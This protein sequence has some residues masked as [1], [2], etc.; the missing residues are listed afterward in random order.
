M[1]KLT[2]LK[3][4]W[5]NE[6]QQ[7]FDTTVTGL[8]KH[9]IVDDL[10]FL[11][12]DDWNTL[13]K[14]TKIPLPLLV[15]LRQH[16]VSTYG[17]FDKQMETTGLQYIQTPFK[18]LNNC[19][20]GGL[21]FD[22]MVEVSSGNTHLLEKFFMKLMEGFLTRYPTGKVIHVDTTGRFQPRLINHPKMPLSQIECYKAFTISTIS[23]SLEEYGALKLASRR[24]H[25]QDQ[26][27]TLIVI[28]DIGYLLDMETVADQVKKFYQVILRLKSMSICVTV[29]HSKPLNTS[30]R[31]DIDWDNLL[32]MRLSLYSSGGEPMANIIKA[33]HVK[34]P[35]SCSLST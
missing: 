21:R 27:S 24:R 25:L 23:Q 9:G 34:T 32:D 17:L 2:F 20:S 3:Q 16:L 22:D 11:M 15:A 8:E 12:V 10:T 26:H 4:K 7:L 31:N 29:S 13:S 1:P 5:T 19:L 28:E 6:Q 30:R 33:R 18:L 35:Q 14:T